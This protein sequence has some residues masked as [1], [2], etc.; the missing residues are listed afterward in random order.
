M[1]P[2]KEGLTTLCINNL[3]HYLSIIR[4]FRIVSLL[5]Q[6]TGL[7]VTSP[8]KEGPTTITKIIS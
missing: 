1:S 2:S 5:T 4:P 8:S 6:T 3:I 7:S